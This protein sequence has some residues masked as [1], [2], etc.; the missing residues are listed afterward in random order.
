MADGQSREVALPPALAEAL[1]A[2]SSYQRLQANRS[3]HTVRAYRGD[4]EAL[5]DHLVAQGITGLD[6][7]GLPDLRSWLADQL[8][9]GL[10]PATFNAAAEPSGSSSAGHG[11]GRSV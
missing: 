5:M 6:E 11:A 7:V 10:A 1:D 4:I 8:A 2:F 9:A 3:E